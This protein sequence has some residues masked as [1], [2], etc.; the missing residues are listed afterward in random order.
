M[1]VLL[2]YPWPGNVRELE[3]VIERAMILADGEFLG[4][5]DLPPDVTGS[6]QFP[7]LSDNLRSAVKAYERER[8][9]QVLTSTGG[10]R[11]QAARRLG[12][13]P[14]TLYRKMA[15]LAIDDV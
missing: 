15:E 1:R 14:S 4:V 9:R 8:I 5:G 13:N 12:I 6:V 10:N 11:E 7:D 2:A 3:N